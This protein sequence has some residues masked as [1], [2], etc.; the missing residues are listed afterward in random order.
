MISIFSEH[1]FLAIFFIYRALK[2]DMESA[3][4]CSSELTLSTLIFTPPPAYKKYQKQEAPQ[5]EIKY[6]EKWIKKGMGKP[7]YERPWFIVTKVRARGEIL[8][9][10]GAR[11]HGVFPVTS[12]SG[13]S[14]NAAATETPLY[15]RLLAVTKKK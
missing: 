5:R 6:Y 3:F 1:L 2:R 15:H 11:E 13:K 4:H 7:W 12:G 10:R 9:Q 14:C 8:R